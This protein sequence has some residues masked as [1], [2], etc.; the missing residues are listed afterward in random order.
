MQN[1]KYGFYYLVGVFLC[2]YFHW[3]HKS[4]S[5]VPSLCRGQ[6]EDQRRRPVCLR[7]AGGE[8]P[9]DSGP[10]GEREPG[11]EDP[12]GRAA[13]GRRQSLRGLLL[14]TLKPPPMEPERRT[15]S[16]RKWLRT[17]NKWGRDGEG[18]RGRAGLVAGGVLWVR[19]TLLFAHSLFNHC[20][21]KGKKTTLKIA[22][23][24]RTYSVLIWPHYACVSFI[25]G[26]GLGD[27]A[28]HQVNSIVPL[29]LIS[30]EVAIYGLSTLVPHPPTPKIICF[31]QHN[32]GF[33]LI[34]FSWLSL[35]RVFQTG[36]LVA[37]SVC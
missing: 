28:V 25:H 35:P 29:T 37:W 12:A 10:V 8:D 7:G 3:S 6:C 5:C 31:N 23:C 11:S 14:H 18:G 4:S 19:M 33:A 36:L 2:A 30:L 16:E 22:W 27:P 1:M 24:V 9:A 20:L 17:R 34:I 15:E 21:S 13:A 26:S 32:T